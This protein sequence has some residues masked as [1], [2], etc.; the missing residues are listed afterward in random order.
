M[1]FGQGLVAM[2]GG[3]YTWC[4]SKYLAVKLPEQSEFLLPSWRGW[5]RFIEWSG[6][7]PHRR[8]WTEERR[9]SL[10]SSG[11]YAWIVVMD[12]DANMGKV[13]Y[14]GGMKIEYESSWFN[15]GHP[16]EMQKTLL[17][18]SQHADKENWRDA[19]IVDTEMIDLSDTKQA[20]Y[21]KRHKVEVTR[22]PD[23]FVDPLTPEGWN[24]DLGKRYQ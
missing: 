17:A 14:S 16:E 21:R 3:T 7:N 24:G 13:I 5:L 9:W 10:I 11:Q 18:V 20:R 15:L 23:E 12:R 4:G 1:K 8:K 6:Q 2:L 19:E 22:V